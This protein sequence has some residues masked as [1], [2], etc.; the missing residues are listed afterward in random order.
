MGG[1][2]D[3]LSLWIKNKLFYVKKWFIILNGMGAGY[4]ELG[5]LAIIHDSD[6]LLYLGFQS[7][8]YISSR[9]MWMD[10]V[11]TFTGTKTE[12]LAQ[13]EGSAWEIWIILC[14]RQATERWGHR[15]TS[16]L[17]DRAPIECEM[18]LKCNVASH[19]QGTC[20]KWPLEYNMA[21]SFNS[22]WWSLNWWWVV[23][24]LRSKMSHQK[25]YL[26]AIDILTRVSSMEK[27]LHNRMPN[28]SISH[29]LHLN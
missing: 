24:Q 19:W 21:T 22:K 26:N 28:A 4:N 17:I 1:L 15:V 12:T 8:H 14:M 2:D 9:R 7:N 10:T 18:T 20:T 6:I 29:L 25:L 16:S 13:Y 5:L 11:T 3:T 23:T 27:N